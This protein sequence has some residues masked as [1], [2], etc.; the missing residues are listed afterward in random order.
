MIKLLLAVLLSTAAIYTNANEVV[1]ILTDYNFDSVVDGSHSVLVEFYAP[2]CGHC[3]S[4]APEYE[5]VAQT[6]NKKSGVIIA[7]L[8]ATAATKVAKRFDVSGF[9][10][11]KWFPRGSTTPEE[12]NGGRSATDFIDFINGR[13]GMNKRLKA[14]PSFVEALT[15]NTF[16]QIV[17]DP[18]VGALVKFYAP[19]CGH[20]KSL[21]PIY[22]E[23]GKTFAN[24]NS[25]V[26]AKLDAEK[27]RNKAQDYDVSGFP[28]LKWFPA[29]DDKVA[30]SY[31]MARDIETLVGFV[32]SQAGTSRKAGGA[33]SDNSGVLSQFSE[34]VAKVSSDGIAEEDVAVAEEI[35]TQLS[36][37]DDIAHGKLYV[38]IFKKILSK[39]LNY[40]ST[41][42]SRLSRMLENGN[43][44]PAKKDL[45]LK[46]LNILSKFNV[47][48][49][50]HVEL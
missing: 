41:E 37:D 9:P 4:L 44:K 19:W 3:K 11:L 26:I 13:T 2:W 6:F 21:A 40:P 30:A 1:T 43:V 5:L 35:V 17:M 7:N 22:E 36:S 16:D 48:Q 38:K 29:G 20:C 31:D 50:S 28:T 27:Y 15:D 12:Y 33:L 46:R 18:S 24:E 14:E 49:D 45:F 34:L 25:V 39:G 8:D 23:L 42:F 47:N 10:T 32:N